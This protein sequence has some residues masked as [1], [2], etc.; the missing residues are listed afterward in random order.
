EAGVGGVFRH[1][2]VTAVGEEVHAAEVHQ[3]LEAEVL[4]VAQ[5]DA[6]FPQLSGGNLVGKFERQRRQAGQRIA[7]TRLDLLGQFPEF[8]G[9]ASALYLAMVLVRRIFFCSWITPNSS[10]SAVG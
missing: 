9:H 6:D 1:P 7:E 10:C 5:R 3:L 2:L 4:L 8:L